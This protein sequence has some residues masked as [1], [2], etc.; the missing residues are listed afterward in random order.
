MRK[1]NKRFQH[2]V[3][4][5]GK[6]GKTDNNK[7]KKEAEK[8]TDEK[9]ATKLGQRN[10]SNLVDPAWLPP[11]RL[12]PSLILSSVCCLSFFFYLTKTLCQKRLFIFFIVCHP[13]VSTFSKFFPSVSVYYCGAP[14]QRPLQKII[15]KWSQWGVYLHGPMKSVV[16]DQCLF[17]MYG[18]IKSKASDK[19]FI[20]MELWRV[21]FHTSGSFT[22]D[23]KSKVSDKWFIYMELW[24]VRFQTSGSYTCDYEE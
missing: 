20:Y 8:R 22:W 10:R 3:S 2:L 15:Q 18:T 21:R 16:S 4:S 13:L 9:E 6:R 1:I 17:Y 11:S 23:Y 14:L 24:R 7:K 5:S 12:S 19:W